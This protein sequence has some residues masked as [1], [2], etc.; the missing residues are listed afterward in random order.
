MSYMNS[1]IFRKNEDMVHIYHYTDV[2]QD[3]EGA[4]HKMLEGGGSLGETGLHDKEFV[5]AVSR[6][7]GGPPSVLL[8]LCEPRCKRREGPSWQ[9]CG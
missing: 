9:R 5:G 8:R 7:K 2:Q 6:T 1:K 4:V 3:L